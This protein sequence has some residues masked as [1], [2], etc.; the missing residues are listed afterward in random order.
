VAWAGEAEPSFPWNGRTR[1]GPGSE[2]RVE[3]R[4]SE[5]VPL[6][7]QPLTVH[8][9]DVAGS[10]PAEPN[11]SISRSL[12]R[13]TGRPLS[14]EFGSASLVWKISLGSA[15]SSWRERSSPSLSRTSKEL[16]VVVRGVP[17]LEGEQRREGNV[18]AKRGDNRI[19]A[20]ESVPYVVEEPLPVGRRALG[21]AIQHAGVG[22]CRLSDVIRFR[23]P[24]EAMRRPCA[25]QELERME[26]IHGQVPE[27]AAAGGCRP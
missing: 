27:A 14:S 16:A 23:L 4:A 10:I 17:A 2:A 13:R 18:A 8:T 9:R 20:A 5:S 6:S 7:P 12:P 26:D 15:R 11:R 1:T 3:P 21:E 24:I 22:D 19:A 25:G